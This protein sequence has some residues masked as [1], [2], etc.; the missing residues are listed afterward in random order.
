MLHML[1]K[2]TNTLFM[3]HHIF[4]MSIVPVIPQSSQTKCSITNYFMNPVMTFL[5]LTSFS[6]GHFSVISASSALCYCNSVSNSNMRIILHMHKR[7]HRAHIYSR[8][9]VRFVTL[10][11]YYDKHYCDSEVINIFVMGT[12]LYSNRSDESFGGWL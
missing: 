1:W 11:K 8:H 2:E 12:W 3:F 10:L 5:Y 4:L 6:T 7:S 9:C